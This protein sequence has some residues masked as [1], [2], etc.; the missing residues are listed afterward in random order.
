MQEFDKMAL[1]YGSVISKSVTTPTYFPSWFNTAN[2][3]GSP[4]I[5]LICL[6]AS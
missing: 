2:A 1:T 6:P 4:S 5:V 3:P